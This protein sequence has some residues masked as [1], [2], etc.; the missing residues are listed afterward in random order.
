MDTQKTRGVVPNYCP[1]LDLNLFGFSK[2]N[3]FLNFPNKQSSLIVLFAFAVIVS[4][5]S[6]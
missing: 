4:N 6:K 1:P 5:G 3:C 2:D